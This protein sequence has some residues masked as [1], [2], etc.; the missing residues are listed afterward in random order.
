[1][2]HLG[3]FPRGETI[4]HWVNTSGLTTGAPSD[5]SSGI[6]LVAYRGTSDTQFSTGI[7]ITTVHDSVT[8]RIRVDVSTTSYALYIPGNNFG[9]MVSD[10]TVDSVSVD[11]RCLFTFSIEKAFDGRVAQVSVSSYTTQVFTLPASTISYDEQLDGYDAKVFIASVAGDLYQPTRVIVDSDSAT[12][13][14]TL[15]R[16]MPSNLSGTLTVRLY[17]GSLAATA[18]EGAIEAARRVMRA[19]QTK[20]SYVID[21]EADHDVISVTYPDGSTLTSGVS[22]ANVLPVTKVAG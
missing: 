10:G 18:D 6:T 3:D 9:V 13:A 2:T 15:D 20:D 11:G 14:I 17:P 8:G 16:P 19:L 22:R 7:S 12:Q 5:A 21:N 4:T 1:M